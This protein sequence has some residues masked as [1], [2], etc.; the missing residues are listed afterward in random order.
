[1]GD[2]DVSRPEAMVLV[3]WDEKG[4][5]SVCGK[6]LGML[7]SEGGTSEDDWTSSTSANSG[8]KVGTHHYG[9]RHYLTSWP[10]G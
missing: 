9:L 1:L 5:C 10:E 3:A 7:A 2:E 8:M 4:D 6:V